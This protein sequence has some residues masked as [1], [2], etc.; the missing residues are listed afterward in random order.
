MC[1]LSQTLKTGLRVR[2]PIKHS[3]ILG[4]V[5]ARLKLENITFREEMH[6]KSHVVFKSLASSLEKEVIV[7]LMSSISKFS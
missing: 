7:E 4:I 6:N 1:T 2:R 5:H 3:F